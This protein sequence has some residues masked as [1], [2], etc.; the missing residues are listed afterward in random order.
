MVFLKSKWYELGVTLV[1]LVATLGSLY[2]SEVMFF[3]PCEL[4]WYQR[5]LMYPLVLIG[6]FNLFKKV[7]DRSLALM[8]LMFSVIGGS[9]SAYHMYIQNFKTEV[10]GMCKGGISCTAKY[11]DIWGFADIPFFCFVAFLMI[12]VL[13]IVKLRENSKSV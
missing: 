5:I 6:G 13:S 12:V 7:T 11:L 1:A 4:C 3:I 2:F 8:M 9:I 10:G